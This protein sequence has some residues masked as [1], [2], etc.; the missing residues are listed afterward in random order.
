MSFGVWERVRTCVCEAVSEASVCPSLSVLM[1][2]V[3]SDLVWSG[4]V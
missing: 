1:L 4:L 2:M 3:G